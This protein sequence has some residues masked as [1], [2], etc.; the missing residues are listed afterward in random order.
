MHTIFHIAEQSAWDLAQ[1]TGSYRVPSLDSEGFIHLSTRIQYSITANRYYRGRTDLVLLEV[2][3][4]ALVDL[5]YE[6]STN[7][8]LFPHLYGPLPVEAV[9][10]VHMFAPDKNGDFSGIAD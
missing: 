8:E 10:R 4:T 3:E 6:V 9:I 7:N 2:D 5:R 1:S